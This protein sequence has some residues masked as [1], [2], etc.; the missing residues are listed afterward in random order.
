MTNSETQSFKRWG[1]NHKR[2]A[3]A[4]LILALLGFIDATY[5]TIAHY[6]GGIVPC[7]IV[8]NCEKVLTSE[9]AIIAGVPVALLGSLYYF[10]IFL[11]AFLSISRKD[12]RFLFAA[13]GFI[14]LGFLSSLWLIYLQLFLI[15]AIC[16]Y[17][18]FSAAITGALF[19]CA[20]SLA[21]VRAKNKKRENDTIIK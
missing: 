18:M 16:L 15:H 9:Y 13:S 17:C 1:I 19:A 21:F 20:A 3:L 10:A 2:I 7:S 6:R 4:F 14:S 5:L 11:F 8:G 12:E